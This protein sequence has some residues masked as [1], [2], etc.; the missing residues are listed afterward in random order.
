MTNVPNPAYSLC[1]H[2]SIETS[3]FP[4]MGALASSLH[5]V[6]QQ[7]QLMEQHVP[8][9]MSNQ[10]PILALAGEIRNRIYRYALVTSQP[11]TVQLQFAPLDTAL[12]R[13]NKQIH[14]EAS[15]IFYHENAFR[16]PQ[17]LF[18]GAEI[19]PQLEKLYRILPTRLRTMRNFVLDFPVSGST[20][21]VKS[22]PFN[23]NTSIRSTDRHQENAS[24]IKATT[25]Y[26]D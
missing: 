7:H 6:K 10:S 2:P 16:F 9:V 21:L 25:I 4:N 14:A 13:V 1:P 18:V 5:S 23:I 8:R 15:S 12:L 17:A 26:Y 19:L 22:R 3:S 20:Q 24:G 11:F